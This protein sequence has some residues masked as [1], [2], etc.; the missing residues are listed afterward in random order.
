MAQAIRAGGVRAARAGQAQAGSLLLNPVRRVAGGAAEAA[1]AAETVGLFARDRE[2]AHIDQTL[3]H[4]LRG[5]PTTL[6]LRGEPGIGKSALIEAAVAQARDFNVVQL[7]AGAG[8]DPTRPPTGWPPP[9]VELFELA[10]PGRRRVA[11]ARLAA[12]VEGLSVYPMAPVLL[13]IDDAHLL[14]QWFLDALVVAVSE[15][16]GHPFGV[17]LALRDSPHMAEIELPPYVLERRLSGLKADQAR[18][19]LDRMDGTRPAGDVAKA[20]TSGVGGN[21]QALFDAYAHLAP[22]VLRGWRALPDPLPIGDGLA[23]AFGE[24]LSGVPAETL[25][26]LAIVAA[27]RAPMDVLEIALHELNLDMTCL[28][29]AAERGIVVLQ[30]NRI[31]FAHPLVRAAAYHLEEVERRSRGHE[32]LSRAFL[33]ADLVELGALHASRSNSVPV[34]EVIGLYGRAVRAAADGGY[35]T[36]A[37]RYEELTADV[38]DT[39]ESVGH[40]LVRAASWWLSAGELGRAVE[41]LDRAAALPAPDHLRGELAYWRCRVS[42]ANGPDARI[43]DELVAGAEL[44]LVRHPARAAEMLAEAATCLLLAGSPTEAQEVAVRAVKISEAVG[45]LTE[46]VAGAVL[47]GVRVLGHLAGEDGIAL[48]GAMTFLTNHPDGIPLSPLFAYVTGLALLEELGPEASVTWAKRIEQM[49]WSGDRSLSCVS[50]LLSALASDRLG[51][52]DEAAEHAALAA[53][54]ARMCGQRFVAIRAGSLLVDLDASRGRYQETFATAAQLLSSSLPDEAEIRAGA[55]RALAELELQQGRV[56]TALGWLRAAEFETDGAAGNIGGLRRGDE[57]RCWVAT[58]AE[59]LAHDQQITGVREL[60]ELVEEAALSGSVAA[61]WG[62]CIRA[63]VTVDLAAAEELFN[64]ALWLARRHKALGARIE[65]LYSCRLKSAGLPDRAASRLRSAI[66]TM[67]E[68]GALGWAALFEIA[69]EVLDVPEQARPDLVLL[70]GGAPLPEG[71]SAGATPLIA[72]SSQRAEDSSQPGAA[73]GWEITLLGSFSVR[74][75]EETIAMPMSLAATALKIVAL[76][77]RILVDE[78]VE[79]LW[80]ESGPGLGM[81]RLRNVLWRIRVGC[82]PILTRDDRFILLSPG[83]VTDV[84]RFR[85]LAAEALEPST[86][87]TDAARIAQAALELYAGELLPA[88]RYADW[89][90]PTRELLARLH[91]QMIELRVSDAIEYDRIQ[92]ATYLLDLLV[93]TDPYEEDHYLRAAEL[94]AKGGN[95]RRALATI[96]RA[97]RTLSE[98]GIPPSDRL[99]ALGASLA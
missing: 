22:D 25:R 53:Q 15:L 14:P 5:E 49:S 16:M 85:Q 67:Q 60:V 36:S 84:S 78:L 63:F 96:G 54:T 30:R 70:R 91:V 72:D 9:L 17:I 57:A 44:S 99:K 79:Q 27:G 3:R 83:A 58:L 69:L 87:P 52:L 89:A 11:P 73:P 75:G 95:R 7:R 82:G 86:A 6:V 94:Q 62:P 68:I 92:E 88:E 20:L 24:V 10:S 13:T 56:P 26:G 38:G 66:A 23:A 12:A 19:L 31:D 97:E 18:A 29:P 45:G 59:V 8:A 48:K 42:L 28:E 90:A 35:M 4:C 2:L 61:A 34:P 41:C 33:E 80:P 32:V 21:P 55:Y 39:A 76:R 1:E 77:R 37:A 46:A 74:R 47:G 65:F 43:A 98:L 71:P 93:E 81:R 40:H 51:R 50:S 64:G